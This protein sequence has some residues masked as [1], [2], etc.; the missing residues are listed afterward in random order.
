MIMSQDSLEEETKRILA[1]ADSNDSEESKSPNKNK[2][3]TWI[4][5]DIDGHETEVNDKDTPDEEW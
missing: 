2:G 3:K 4:E 1:L 5:K